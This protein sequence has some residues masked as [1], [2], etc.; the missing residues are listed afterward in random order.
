MTSAGQFDHRR[1]GVQVTVRPI[2]P[3]SDLELAKRLLTVQH[4]A[5]LVEAGII[6]DD[7]I[8]PLNETLADVQQAPVN[9]L[10]AFGA[11]PDALID[12]DPLVDADAPVN[13]DTLVGAVAW[14]ENDRGIDIDRL[15]VDPTQARRGIGTALVAAIEDLAGGREITVSTGRGNE[16]AAALY[17]AHGFLHAGDIEVVPTLWVSQYVRPGA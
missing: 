4:A 6:Q 15:V 5:Y 2:T 1:P 14:T 8:P 12:A 17:A 11:D 10:G 13:P 16:P 7:R 3:G 9:W